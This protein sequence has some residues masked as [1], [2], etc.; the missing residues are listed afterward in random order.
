MKIQYGTILATSAIST[1]CA[2]QSPGLN[3]KRSFALQSFMD[4]AQ[5]ARAQTAMSSGFK[6]SLDRQGMVGS[7]DLAKKAWQISPMVRI[8]GKTRKTFQFHDIT[9]EVVQVTIESDGRPIHSDIE[10][11]IGPDWTPMKMSVYSEDG[12]V[13]PV[14]TL[15]GTRNMM[16]NIEVRNTADYQFPM[17]AGAAQATPALT[18]LR[19][20]ILAEGPSRYI[21]GGGAVKSFDFP[22][23]VD[24]IQVCLSTDTRQLDARVELL[25]GPNNYKQVYSIFTNNGLKN[26]LFIVFNTPGSGNVVRVRNMAPLEFPCKASVAPVE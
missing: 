13:R 12:R 17:R 26:S 22:P 3:A 25:N 11:W 7:Q 1:A 4:E 24:Q 6:D 23:N 19:S 5:D 20:T 15:V 8:E 21:E 2:F 10:L 9:K 16:N 14:Q 18:Q